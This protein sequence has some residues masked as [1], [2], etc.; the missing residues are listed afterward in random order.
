[1]LDLLSAEELK[2]DPSLRTFSA[3]DRVLFNHPEK[4]RDKR[5]DLWEDAIIK[6]RHGG[7]VYTI[8]LSRTQRSTL[9][10]IR[11]L[12]PSSETSPPA[13]RSFLPHPLN[14]P[15]PPSS[16]LSDSQPSPPSPPHASSPIPLAPSEPTLGELPSIHDFHQGEMIIWEVS[17]TQK[18]FLGKVVGID[19]KTELLE[20]HAWGSLR[21]GALKNRMF[22]PMWRRP[23]GHR[24]R[25]Q[26][27]QPPSHNPDICIIAL[28]EIRE[29]CISLSPEGRLPH[30]TLAALSVTTAES[31]YR[32]SLDPS[33]C[34]AAFAAS[35]T[36]SEPCSNATTH[37]LVR[38]RDLK[39]PEEQAQ[40]QAGR[41]KE[42][43][44]FE[45]Y[46]VKESIPIDAVPPSARRTAIPL[47]WRDTL[48]RVSEHERIFK[49]RLCA[50]GSPRF[51]RQSDIPVSNVTAAQWGLRIA[52]CIAFAFPELNPLTSFLLADIEN[53]YLTAPRPDSPSGE[54]TYVRP[55]PDH[56][57]YHTH[58]WLLLKAVY[59]LKDSGFIFDRH[60]DRAL[61]KVGWVKSGVP[62]L[63]WKWSG[64]PG[65][66]SSQLLGLCATFVDDLAV[67]GIGASPSDLVN[68]IA[69]KGPFT[70]TKVKAD[71][72]GCARWAEVDI[73]LRQD[74]I[75]LS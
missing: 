51:D 40:H 74:K 57:E 4:Q 1:M 5:E 6:Q 61:L 52:L 26:H 30:S 13:S 67:I 10:H 11:C 43:G 63:W 54:P 32:P 64:Q 47:I 34:P 12:R 44:K 38:V 53:A 60:R 71:T 37:I 66:E 27:Q 25:Y 41:K 24:I 56:P 48:K 19:E 75:R 46:G 70:I 17:E 9:A 62:G 2:N 29:R 39:D 14:P 42:L 3:G 8:Q 72:N 31:E 21:H 7:H 58:L 69:S 36:A 28:D 16:S 33:V 55:P 50:N 59:G 65:A 35:A 45:T 23:T 22:A 49:S 68:E 18:R 73:E 20:V 15:H